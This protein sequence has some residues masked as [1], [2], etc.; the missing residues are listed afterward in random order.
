L[1]RP[2][3]VEEGDVLAEHDPCH[4]R[5]G[6]QSLAYGRLDRP[7]HFAN[8]SSILGSEDGEHD[9]RCAPDLGELHDLSSPDF[10]TI[11]RWTTYAASAVLRCAHRKPCC[12]Q[13]RMQFRWA[14]APSWCSLAFRARTPGPSRSS[15]ILRVPRARTPSGKHRRRP[16]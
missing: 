3:S 15:C 2:A 11:L 1:M 5:C 10:S 16:P 8:G 4:A 7:Q 14:D 9:Y 13:P 6:P 12:L